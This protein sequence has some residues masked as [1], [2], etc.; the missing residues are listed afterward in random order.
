MKDLTIKLL[1]AEGEIIQE[2]SAE[3]NVMPTQS[4][5]DYYAERVRKLIEIAENRPELRDHYH[6]VMEIRTK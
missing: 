3:I 5:I 6:I 2:G 4:V 1:D